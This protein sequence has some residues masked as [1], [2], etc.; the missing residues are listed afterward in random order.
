MEE[1]I[2]DQ[3]DIVSGSLR[4]GIIPTV[5]PYLIPLFATSFLKNILK[6]SCQ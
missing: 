4:I 5:A 2:D 3:R 1:L 6:F